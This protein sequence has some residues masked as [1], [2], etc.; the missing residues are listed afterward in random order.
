MSYVYPERESKSLEFKSRLPNF[1]NLIKTCVAFA[2]GMGG[3]IIIGVDDK[4]REIVGIDDHIRNRVYDDFPNSLYDATSP[5]LFAKIYEKRFS[6]LNVII[7]EIPYGIK[8]PV[9]VKQ[10]GMPDGI[11]LRAGS[12]TRRATQEY[13]DELMRARI[14]AHNF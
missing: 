12:S 5:S 3:R 6:D 11:Y 13:I 14:S 1:S 10:E 4:S 9:F 7:I 2:N 8:K